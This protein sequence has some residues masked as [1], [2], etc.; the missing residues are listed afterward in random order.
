[1]SDVTR[2]SE[3]L[4]LLQKTSDA[5]Q[6]MLESWFRSG[7]RGFLYRIG[8]TDADIGPEPMFEGDKRS[9][10]DGE[11]SRGRQE[12][13]EFLARMAHLDFEHRNA[14]A[15]WFIWSDRSELLRVGATNEEIGRSRVS[16][17]G[18]WP[19]DRDHDESQDGTFFIQ[20][21]QPDVCVSRIKIGD[22]WIDGVV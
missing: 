14:I 15:F 7:Y 9:A 6:H 17:D 22:G 5:E 3:A 19:E 12:V 4:L 8:L 10:Y 20:E 13:R 16:P 11:V 1:M 2:L 21:V 18:L